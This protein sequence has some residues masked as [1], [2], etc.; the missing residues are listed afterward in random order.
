MSAIG[1]PFSTAG[2]SHDRNDQTFE[3]NHRGV[4]ELFHIVENVNGKLHIKNRR[5]NY[6]KQMLNML[7]ILI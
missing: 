1:N 4:R 3:Q 6:R 5:E 7:H 2:I